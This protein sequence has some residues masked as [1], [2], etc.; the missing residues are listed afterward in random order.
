MLYRR[1]VMSELNSRREEFVDFGRAVRGEVREAAARLRAL[2][3]ETSE[4]LRARAGGAR[5]SLPSAELEERGALSVQFGRAWRSHEEARL[6][7]AGLL[8]GRVTFAADGSQIYPGREVSLPVAAVQVAS[9]ENPHTAEGTYTKE[10]QF[11][12]I[13][14]SELL[15]GDHAYEAPEQV[16]GVRRLQL[17]VKTI[18]EFLVRQRGWREEGRRAPVAFLDGTLLFSRSRKGDSSFTDPQAAALAGLVEVSRETGVP[19]VGYVDHSYAPDIRNALRAL[20]D[21]LPEVSVYDAQVLRAGGTAADSARPLL[22]AW[23]DRTIFW[24]CRRPNLDAGFYDERGEPTVGFVYLQTTAAG[25]PSRVEVPAWVREAGLLEEVLD[26]VRA[27]CVVGN[28]YP[29][30]IETADAAA[31]MTAR[32]REQ[33]LRVMQDFAD[34]H[35]FEFRVSRKPLSKARRR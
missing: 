11:K 4:G 34:E 2:A 30:V 35:S 20:D 9:F 33:F 12:I 7:A 24:L 26:V 23:G 18:T 15:Q 28:G 8:R 25:N 17:E 29:Y 31:A 32:D 3:G 27:E 13:A 19:V 21:T 1:R 5:V 14:P 6:W 10:A 16:V 22:G